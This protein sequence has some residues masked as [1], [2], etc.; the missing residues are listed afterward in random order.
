AAAPKQEP[1]GPAA[2]VAKGG[3][4]WSGWDAL[5]LDGSAST[6]GGNA[7]TVSAGNGA[8][9]KHLTYAWR[10]TGGPPLVILDPTSAVTSVTGLAAL[11]PSWRSSICKFELTVT[12]AN[13]AHDTAGVVYTVR[14]APPLRTRPAAE[15]SFEDRDGYQL[16]HFVIWQT[17]YDG[18]AA[19]FEVA[20]D[21]ELTFERLAGGG[22]A[23]SGGR[24]DLGWVYQIAVYPV[25][26][27]AQSWLEFLVN[28]EEKIPAVLQ[29]GVN[30]DVRPEAP[31]ALPQT[32][33]A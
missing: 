22:Y 29:L 17:N 2:R 4:V 23:V 8:D 21:S 24:T 32:E 3:V 26:G 5:A 1:A 30:W 18:L 31:P 20:S 13:G 14:F 7:G 16:P 33:G 28:T 19:T 11:R 15:R 25:S 6:G 10:Q 27:E 9:G 12:D